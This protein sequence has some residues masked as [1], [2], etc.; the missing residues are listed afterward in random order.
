MSTLYV[1]EPGARIEREYQQVL[2][3]KDDEVLAR[4]PLNRVSHVVLV[5]NVGATTPALL[6][7]LD[8]GISLA[9]VRPSGE[10]RGRLTP[11]SGLNWPLRQAQYRSES[12]PAVCLA[13]A[14]AVVRGKLHNS[15]TMM[16]RLLRRREELPADLLA[17]V[18]A[19][20]AQVDQAPAMDA[21]RG[22][23]GSAARAYFGLL[24]AALRPE[25][26]FEKRARR[27]PPDPANSLLSLGY[28]LLTEALMTALEVVG[29]D[30]YVGFFHADK[31]GRP[32]LALDLVEEFRAPIVDSL[33]LTLANKRMIG[34]EDFEK[35]GEREGEEA[36]SGQAS[37]EPAS[38]PSQSAVYLNR[39]GRRVFFREFADRLETETLHPL[40]GRRLSYRKIFEVQARLAAKVISGEAEV[41]RAFL[42]R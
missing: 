32:A 26:A 8:H 2:V 21:L 30:P 24:R 3:T 39:H 34:P 5:G 42:W 36:D 18:E 23:E 14:R 4:V 13:F 22:I 11:A 33:V 19:A 20:Q 12:D 29:L 6:A 40:V 41:Y 17:Q 28:T 37:S 15:R 7:L 16:Q 10:L 1:T 25:M 27:P 31:Y 9:L 38:R 35:A